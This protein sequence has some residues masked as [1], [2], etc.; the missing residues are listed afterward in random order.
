MKGRRCFLSRSARRAWAL[1]MLVAMVPACASSPSQTAPTTPP[2][3][4][5]LEP[6]DAITVSFSLEPE[7][8]GTYSV[9][10]TSTVALPFLGSRSVAGLLPA[11]LEANLMA[12]YESRLQNQAVDVRL[13]RRVRV[14]GSVGTPGLY[15]VDA[16]MT[17]ADVVAQAGGATTDGDVD[18]I[19]ISRE[20]SGVRT[21]I[22]MGAGAFEDLQSGDEIFVPQRGWF[23]RNGVILLSAAVSAAAIIA[24]AALY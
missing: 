8:S 1:V 10:E 19:Q 22:G 21:E 17:L 7:Q 15:H 11:E 24:A 14:L 20:G 4:S 12:E 16:T 2:E 6:G 3:P 13:L 23:A 5:P 18:A 9:D